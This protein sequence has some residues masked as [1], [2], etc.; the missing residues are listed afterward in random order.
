MRRRLVITAV[1]LTGMLGLTAGPA[2]A[3]GGSQPS[4]GVM[5]VKLSG[6]P[7]CVQSLF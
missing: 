6:K 7:L 5:C 3:T 1:M 4:T 2:L